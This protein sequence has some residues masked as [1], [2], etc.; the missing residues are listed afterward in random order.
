MATQPGNEE[1]TLLYYVDVQTAYP[2]PSS[3]WAE[4]ANGRRWGL[5]APYT[6]RVWFSRRIDARKAVRHLHNKCVHAR[7]GVCT[8]LRTSGSY[9]TY[10]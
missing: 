7:D 2:L 3:A 8:W 6:C 9:G 4:V 10:H 1:Q 5:I